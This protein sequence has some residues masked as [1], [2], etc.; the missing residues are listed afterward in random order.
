VVFTQWTP[1]YTSVS[2]LFCICYVWF[3]ASCHT[4]QAEVL[5]F[6]ET[7]LNLYHTA[8]CHTSNNSTASDEQLCNPQSKQPLSVLSFRLPRT[9]TLASHS[10]CYITRYVTQ[11]IGRPSFLHLVVTFPF[12]GFFISFSRFRTELYSG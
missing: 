10:Q 12:F 7:C 8:P 6:S 2:P 1:P 9:Q 3:I 11:S 5:G 4:A